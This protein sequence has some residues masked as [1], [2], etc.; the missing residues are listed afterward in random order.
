M[1]GKYIKVL[2]RSCRWKAGTSQR[3]HGTGAGKEVVF[4]TPLSSGLPPL[5]ITEDRLS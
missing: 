1:Q 2:G 5:P 4:V 3:L